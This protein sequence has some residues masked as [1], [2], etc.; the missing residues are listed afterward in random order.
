[1]IK[2]IV[3]LATI[4]FVGSFLIYGVVS[5]KTKFAKNLIKSVGFG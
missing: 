1:M 4:A 2:K 5:D 3:L